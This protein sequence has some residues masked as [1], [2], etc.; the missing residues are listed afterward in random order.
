MS[1][2]KAY[3][4]D[5]QTWLVDHGGDRTAGGEGSIVVTAPGEPLPTRLVGLVGELRSTEEIFAAGNAGEKRYREE[6]RV[7]IT[8]LV[9]RSSS[10][11]V[12]TIDE[13]PFSIRELVRRGGMVALVLERV[14]VRSKQRAGAEWGG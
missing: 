1:T 2:G 6:L 11:V 4:R 10:V 12:E 14:R 13:I 7:S 8:Q 3:F 9:H 5:A